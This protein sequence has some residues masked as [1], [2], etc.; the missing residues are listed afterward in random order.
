MPALP[1]W[2]W[3][4]P[5]R[6]ATRTEMARN[7]ASLTPIRLARRQVG[8]GSPCGY[9]PV[10]KSRV[11]RQRKRIPDLHGSP[12]AIRSSQSLR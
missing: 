4:P 5:V 10:G 3:T 12:Q 8:V 6:R 11:F 9:R 7:Q 1:R 2:T